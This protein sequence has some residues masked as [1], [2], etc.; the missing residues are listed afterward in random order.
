MKQGIVKLV[1]KMLIGFAGQ[2]NLWEAI[3]QIVEVRGKLKLMKFDLEKEEG[4]ELRRIEY[5]VR[6]SK[7]RQRLDKELHQEAKK[8]NKRKKKREKKNISDAAD[9]TD[10]A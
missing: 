10:S 5:E 1:L 4:E 6:E 2:D 8:K 3:K 7:E 9:T